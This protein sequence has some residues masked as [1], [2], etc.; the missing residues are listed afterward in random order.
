MI[1][2]KTPSKPRTAAK[3]EAG[4]G[5]PEATCSA[6]QDYAFDVTANLR[7]ALESRPWE[8]THNVPTIDIMGAIQLI[9]AGIPNLR[10]AERVT[11]L[12]RIGATWIIKV[13]GKEVGI[14]DIRDAIDQAS[15]I[16]MPNV[17]VKRG[18][19]DSAKD[20]TDSPSLLPS[21]SLSSSLKGGEL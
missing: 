20:G 13:D 21:C 4:G 18:A 19:E 11:A 10:D 3:Q 8:A 14:G 1:K 9:Q 5:C 15:A 17:E 7:K 6:L 2:K 16:C 12:A